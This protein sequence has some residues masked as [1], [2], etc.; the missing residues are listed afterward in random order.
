M[1]E[2]AIMQAISTVGFPIVMCI[3]LLYY[4][5]KNDERYD[6]EIQKLVESVNENTKATIQLAQKIDNVP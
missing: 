3:I 2:N 4:M 1:D 5:H 6:A